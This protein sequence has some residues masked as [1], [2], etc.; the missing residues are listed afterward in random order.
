MIVESTK[1]VDLRDNDY[2]GIWFKNNIIIPFLGEE[3]WIPVSIK[4]ELE[5]PISIMVCVRDNHLFFN[6]ENI[7]I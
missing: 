2:K 6:A 4:N 3:M 1:P 7:G 5:T